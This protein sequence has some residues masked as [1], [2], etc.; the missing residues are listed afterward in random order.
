MLHNYMLKIIKNKNHNFFVMI[1][2]IMSYLDEL[3]ILT[4]EC[5]KSYDFFIII[6]CGSIYIYTIFGTY[7]L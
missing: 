3:Y 4:F 6:N 1:I 2:E 5:M 7:I